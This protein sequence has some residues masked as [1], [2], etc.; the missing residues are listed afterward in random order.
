MAHPLVPSLPETLGLPHGLWPSRVRRRVVGALPILLL[1]H[2]RLPL[3]VAPVRERVWEVT[4]PPP[5]S[6]TAL[7]LGVRLLGVP[8][9]RLPL[10]ESQSPLVWVVA[11]TLPVRL[12]PR[13]PVLG[14]RVRVTVQ[15]LEPVC[16]YEGPWHQHRV[17]ARVGDV[18]RQP[19][20]H[21]LPDLE[22]HLRVMAVY[23]D[24]HLAVIRQVL[25]LVVR[26][27]PV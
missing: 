2:R 26:P 11:R 18:L 6:V 25:P 14:P 19:A 5:P 22:H 9:D 3:L 24:P 13:L 16:R 4:R 1:L 27:V 17:V 7:L 20:V 10:P 12:V 15:H 23:R 21:F 8:P